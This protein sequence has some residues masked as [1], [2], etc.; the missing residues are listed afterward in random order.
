MSVN[1]K[2]QPSQLRSAKIEFMCKITQFQVNLN[3]ATTGHK[4]QGM[5]KDALFMC[6]FPDQK[7]RALF[8]NWENVVLSRIRKSKGL[9]IFEPIDMNRLFE[10]SE[11]VQ[12]YIVCARR[13]E[14]QLLNARANCMTVM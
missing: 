14:K 1:V 7:L 9:Y 12:K 6:S 4:L 5:S 13:K 10:P 11:Q 8:K 2:V 3:N